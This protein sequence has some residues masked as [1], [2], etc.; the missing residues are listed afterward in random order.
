MYTSHWLDDR[1]IKTK[2]M[3]ILTHFPVLVGFHSLVALQFVTSCRR[4]LENAFHPLH[5][6]LSFRFHLKRIIFSSPAPWTFAFTTRNSSQG[7]TWKLI[8]PQRKMR[9]V[10]Q[11]ALFE[12]SFPGEE[13]CWQTRCHVKH[14]LGCLPASLHLLWVQLVIGVP[15]NPPIPIWGPS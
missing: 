2:L 9:R 15:L 8:W 14:R 7:R 12:G 5:P 1:A 6:L 4:F 13:N 11:H 3:S 10:C